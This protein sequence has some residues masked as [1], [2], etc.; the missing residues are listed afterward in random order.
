[1]QA[2]GTFAVRAA[3][4]LGLFG[5]EAMPEAEA[6]DA[7]LIRADQTNLLYLQLPRALA[8]N[9]AVAAVLSM[10]IWSQV[11]TATLAL[12]W[13]A[14]LAVCGGWLALYHARR[15]HRAP[16]DPAWLTRFAAGALCAGAAWGIG[17]MLLF[18]AIA[19]E[20]RMLLAFVLAGVLAGGIPLLSA[21][22]QV[23][24]AYALAFA[25]P[26]GYVLL[27]AQNSVL[28]AAGLLL[29]LFLL[30][31]LGSA[32]Q[33]STSVAQALRMRRAYRAAAG[34]RSTLEAQL[35]EQLEQL[36]HAH[37][38]I[39]ASGRKLALYVDRA[40]IAVFEVDAQGT[41]LNANPMAESMFGFPALEIEGRSLQR[42]LFAPD[43]PL[44][45][46]TEWR[47]FVKA[48]VPLAG[49]HAPCLR[50]DALEILCEFSLT[51][52]VGPDGDL[53]SVIVHC[54]DITQQV[55]AERIKQEF[56]STL[57]HELRTPLTSIIGSLQLVNAGILGELSQDVLELTTVAER[58]A[59]RL[60]DII[61]DILDI[62]KIESGR[63]TLLV[64]TIQLPELVKDSVVLNRAF[65]ERH[66]VGLE[67]ADLGEPLAVAVDRKRLLQVITNLISNAA[68]FCGEGEKVEV[69]V[70]REAGMARIAVDDRGPGIPPEFR[71]RIFSRFAQADS[72]YT[73]KKGGTGLG[74]AISKRLTELM[75]GSIGFA[76]REG[77]GTRF[78]IDLPIAEGG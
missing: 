2:D 21:V 50:S 49:R 46:A 61:N 10:L 6:I 34:E 76:D 4:G 16:G 5:D 67:F 59:Q 26:I 3:R 30:V 64:E 12:W 62:E 44:L 38:E 25:V 58:N 17:G 55:E 23:Y 54:Q 36:A 1:M 39:A 71:N 19:D 68:K 28:V 74:L 35:V 51:P 53:V 69:S 78:F 56:T 63:F 65:A 27:T 72:S 24:A 75:G 7:A 52:L 15:R 73:R 70:R 57:S 32:L 47:D 8:V 22:W 42:V 29:P 20:E 45:A 37:E 66:K 41:I 77:G 40:P 31:N 43:R 60:L 18:R 48:G 33:L 9:L 13:L 14:L 11:P